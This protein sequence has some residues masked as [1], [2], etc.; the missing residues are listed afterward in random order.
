MRSALRCFVHGEYA[1]EF[2]IRNGVPIGS[3]YVYPHVCADFASDCDNLSRPEGILRV[4]FVGRL[5]EVKGVDVLLRAVALARDAGAEIDLRLCGD[6]PLRQDL[7]SL[8]KELGLRPSFLGH[9][10]PSEVSAVMSWCDVLTL[11]SRQIGDLY[12]GWG[13]VVGEAASLSKALLVSSVVGCAPELVQHG[14]NGFVLPQGD[15]RAWADALI[16]LAEHPDVVER[17]GRASRQRF[18]DYNDPSRCVDLLREALASR[19]MRTI[20]GE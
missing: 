15:V 11:P 4:V 8:A 7:E 1:K 9:L 20:V 10:P 16:R 2:A 17:M 6:G 13:L 18:D 5:V 14:V 3:I 19:G 12:E